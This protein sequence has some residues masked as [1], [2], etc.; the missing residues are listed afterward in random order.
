MRK[1]D[2]LAIAFALFNL[3]DSPMKI[4]RSYDTMGMPKEQLRVREVWTDK[5]LDTS[6]PNAR[7]IDMEIQPHGALLLE[8]RR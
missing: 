1:F 4:D 5:V 8:L 6:G 3:G 7:R 2:W